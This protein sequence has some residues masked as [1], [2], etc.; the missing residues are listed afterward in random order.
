MKRH[1]I[2][3]YTY[4][5]GDSFI[6]LTEHD[7]GGWVAYIEAK[8]VVTKLENRIIQLEAECKALMEMLGK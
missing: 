3:I 1:K 5:F 2:D 7:L 4:G 8:R 6:D